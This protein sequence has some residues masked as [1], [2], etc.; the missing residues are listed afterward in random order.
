MPW[1][2]TVWRGCGFT[3]VLWC[4]AC[5]GSSLCL[6]R[7]SGLFLGEAA[8]QTLAHGCPWVGVPPALAQ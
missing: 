7:A 1:F 8:V 5:R 6:C 3:C 2:V 4:G